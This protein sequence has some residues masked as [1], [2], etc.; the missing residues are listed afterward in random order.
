MLLN[1][2]MYHNLETLCVLSFMDLKLKYQSSFLGFLW[3]FVKPLLQFLVYFSIFGLILKITTEQDYALKLFY[4]VLIWAWFS[5]ATGLSLNAYIGKRSIISK[6]RT[7]K[8]LPP[9]AAYLTPTINYCLNFIIFILAYIFFAKSK[10]ESIFAII[11]VVVF[12]GSFVAIS[13]FIIAINL[14]L[15]NLNVFYRDFQ[16]VWELILTYGVFLTP[17]IYRLPIPKQYQT[18]YYCTNL[19]AFPLQSLKSI[20]FENQDKIYCNGRLLICYTIS[21]SVLFLFSLY[22][23]KRFKDKIVDF[24]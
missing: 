17:I 24:L 14:I 10:P 8:L 20:F 21:L 23:Y 5:E 3:S 1:K 18:L 16:P 11:N 7:N 12:V 15:A 13:L 19:L 4:G 9:L 6:I 2:K 22:I